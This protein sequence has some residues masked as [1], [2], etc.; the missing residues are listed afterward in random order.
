M[1]VDTRSFLP[2]MAA[3]VHGPGMFVVVTS[4]MCVD[5]GSLFLAEEVCG[6]Q[7]RWFAWLDGGQTRVSM[8]SGVELLK[9]T[10]AAS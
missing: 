9:C 5:C 10:V 8:S 3:M 4:G 1:Y 6:R 7:T 2:A